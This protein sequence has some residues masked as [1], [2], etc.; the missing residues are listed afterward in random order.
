MP[1]YRHGCAECQAAREQRRLDRTA[2]DMRALR[3]S[4]NP[5]QRIRG[6]LG[7][8]QGEAASAIG[9]TRQRWMA[10]ETRCGGVQ[11]RAHD[12]LCMRFGAIL[13]RLQIDPQSLRAR[14]SGSIRAAEIEAFRAEQRALRE[15]AQT[16]ESSAPIPDD[17]A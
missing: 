5:W 13:D 11:S 10:L 12:L 7:C 2:Q 14:K 15:A 17:A 1:D 4:S 16:K 3:R 8:T 6:E 9:L